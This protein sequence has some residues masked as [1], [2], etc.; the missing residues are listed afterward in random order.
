[1]RTSTLRS[2]AAVMALASVSTLPLGAQQ[3]IGVS[4]D[5]RGLSFGKGS[6]ADAAQLLV[7]PLAV[8]YEVTPSL[9]LDLY[10]AWA[11][12][13]AQQNDVAYTL[14][15][16]VDTQVKATYRATPWALLSVK[17]NLPT[18]HATHD[19][20]EAVVASVLSSDLL[21]F[22]ESTW[23]MGTGITSSVATAVRAGGF[24]IGMAAAYSVNGQFQPSSE[25]S[26]KY[27]PGNE[28]LVRVGI[29]RN[30]GTS[31]LTAGGTFMTYT[32]DRAD[33]TNLFQAGKRVRVDAAYE[34]RSAAGVWTLYAADL[35][36]EHGDVT[37]PFVDTTGAT[38]GDTTYA[39]PSQN[40][41]AVGFQGAV[42][43]GGSYVFR[44][45]VDLRLQT[46]GDP[47]RN[48]QGSG[49][50]VG[51]GGDFPLR[52][53]GSY[54][55]FPKAQILFGSAK[56]PT[57]ADRGILGLEVSATVRWGF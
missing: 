22:R 18:G 20:Q 34:F 54:D 36:R 7:V 9:A 33:G 14:S 11:Q 2:V 5:Y 24:G 57:G 55:F 4:A 47:Q 29:D 39:T 43:L 40:L 31:T 3:A 13:K 48:N 8:R 16:L 6:A 30:I 49:W 50:I 38:V 21:G 53:F 12:G 23:G 17:A 10:A 46:R 44:P 15:G 1:M 27:Q 51:V 32:S 25:E 41:L 45:A 52:V 42:G 56:D 37:L 35:W 19:G 28:T 26:L